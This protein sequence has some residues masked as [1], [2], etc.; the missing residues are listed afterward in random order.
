MNLVKKRKVRGPVG[1]LRGWVERARGSL[2]SPFRSHSGYPVVPVHNW[3]WTRGPHLI[4]LVM[5]AAIKEVSQN[6]QGR[7]RVV[8]YK[9]I[10]KE[11]LLWM[12]I[13]N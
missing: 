3:D 13:E 11:W 4:L 1:P 2:A 9:L 7:T 10:N 5:G 6:F 12:L 8:L